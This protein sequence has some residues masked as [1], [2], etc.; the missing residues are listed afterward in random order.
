MNPKDWHL[1]LYLLGGGVVA[2]QTDHL[3]TYGHIILGVALFISVVEILAEAA[4]GISEV[5]T[6][7]Q[8]RKAQAAWDRKHAEAVAREAEWNSAWKRINERNAS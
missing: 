1:V 6:Q 5:V 2:Q 7:R 4:D 8:R 3:L